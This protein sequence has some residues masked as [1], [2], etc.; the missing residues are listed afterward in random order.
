MQIAL[1]SLSLKAAG[2]DLK[3]TELLIKLYAQYGPLPPPDGDDIDA[4][5]DQ[6]ALEELKAHI[7]KY[8]TKRDGSPD[9]GI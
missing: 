8:G 3:A 5:A 4:A 9:I 2:G 6:A 7:L 1:E